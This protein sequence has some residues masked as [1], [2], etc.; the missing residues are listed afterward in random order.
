MHKVEEVHGRKIPVRTNHWIGTQ[1]M[2]RETLNRNATRRQTQIQPRGTAARSGVSGGQAAGLMDRFMLVSYSMGV[3]QPRLNRQWRQWSVR[4]I[5]VMI[6]V[7][8]SSPAR[9]RLRSRTLFC[10][11]AKKDSSAAKSAATPTFPI[12]PMKW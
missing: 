1:R 5:Q 12:D 6:A 3:N 10:S 11:S 8:S 4:S 7:R 9:H 2:I